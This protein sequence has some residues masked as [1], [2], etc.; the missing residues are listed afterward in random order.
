MKG[1]HM[2]IPTPS[3]L[4]PPFLPPSLSPSSYLAILLANPA[5]AL[6]KLSLSLPGPSARKT[7]ANTLI[8]ECQRCRAWSTVSVRVTGDGMGGL[9]GGGREGGRGGRGSKY[10]YVTKAIY[11]SIFRSTDHI[12]MYFLYNQYCTTQSLC[13]GECYM[14]EEKKGRCVLYAQDSTIHTI[15]A[16]S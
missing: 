1:T 16:Y 8:Q 14:K 3:S 12:H 11:V 6:R 5:L 9:E 13:G 15:I 7:W 4:F 10:E 2:L